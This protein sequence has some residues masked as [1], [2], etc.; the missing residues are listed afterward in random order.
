MEG[1]QLREILFSYRKQWTRACE[2]QEVY[3]WE[4]SSILELLMEISCPFIESYPHNN[5]QLFNLFSLFVGKNCFSLPFPYFSELRFKSV[6]LSTNPDALQPSIESSTSASAYAIQNRSRLDF[7]RTGNKTGQINK[8]GQAIHR[9]D[10]SRRRRPPPSN[11][12]MLCKICLTSWFLS[13]HL[14]GMTILDT[15]RTISLNQICMEM[16]RN[17]TASWR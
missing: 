14:R 8:H 2:T 12:C 10:R 1:R 16:R 13:T 4:C 3:I 15:E 9:N 17:L 5:V 7:S 6:R 11:A